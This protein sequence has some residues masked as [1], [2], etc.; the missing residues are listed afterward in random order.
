MPTLRKPLDRLAKCVARRTGRS[1][2]Q[3]ADG[4][5]VDQTGGPDGV[6]PPSRPVRPWRRR[7]GF[8]G[9]CSGSPR[10]LS[11][12]SIRGERDEAV[13]AQLQ[14]E[15]HARRAVLSGLVRP[16]RDPVVHLGQRA[17]RAQPAAGGRRLPVAVLD[18]HPGELAVRVPPAV[19]LCGPDQLPDPP[20]QPRIQ[21]QRR[22]DA[23]VAQPDRE[24]AEVAG[25]SRRRWQDQGGQQL[26][27]GAVMENTAAAIL[28]GLGTMLVVAAVV[29]GLVLA[30]YRLADKS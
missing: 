5:P 7:R 14:P 6:R 13:V 16:A 9:R 1:R 28:A 20:Q 3:L 10:L 29:A 8:L 15:H 18:Q 21:R 12:V 2:I 11:Y 30:A 27:G 24:S 26:T 19:D 4:W 22:G 23:T 25:G 17:A